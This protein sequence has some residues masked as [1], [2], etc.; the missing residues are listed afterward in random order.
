[1]SESGSIFGD[2]GWI[3]DIWG[4]LNN[5]DDKPKAGSEFSADNPSPTWGQDGS[6]TEEEAGP[7]EEGNSFWEKAASA[8]GVT[9]DYLKE[10]PWLQQ[11]VR[12]AGIRIFSD[13][14]SFD[15]DRFK[16]A[17][18]DTTVMRS[19]DYFNQFGQSQVVVDPETGKK[20][21]TGEMA[22]WLTDMV[23]A[24]VSRSASPMNAYQKPEA[25]NALLGEYIGDREDY[26]G[27]PRSGSKGSQHNVGGYGSPV[28]IDIGGPMSPKAPG[29]DPTGGGSAPTIEDNLG[30]GNPGAL[31]PP[32]LIEPD[33]G[34]TGVGQGED[35][36]TGVGQNQPGYIDR[37]NQGLI[38]GWSQ[39]QDQLQ[40]AGVPQGEIDSLRNYYERGTNGE[41]GFE[42][43][44]HWKN[45]VGSALAAASGN[46][47]RLIYNIGKGLFDHFRHDP[48]ETV[49]VDPNGETVRDEYLPPGQ[50]WV[51]PGS[52]SGLYTGDGP[53]WGIPYNPGMPA[54][55]WQV[56][57]NTPPQTSDS[58][59]TVGS[60]LIG[61]PG[62]G[63]GVGDTM[64]V[65]GVTYKYVDGKWIPQ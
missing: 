48:W 63:I 2:Y 21:V 18:I 37:E 55:F 14:P 23:N 6:V 27:I 28:N 32:G 34:D 20:T 54:D 30:Y 3:G 56:G 26:F 53:D 36:G 40:S 10:N 45:I 46:P 5:D 12:Q 52:D 25:F 8:F 42:F 60:D 35:I 51:R 38:D 62:T 64:V 22:P 16:Q 1:M 47:L 39:W 44:N 65:D 4:A 7:V 59:G 58:G 57:G 13:K 49:P 11:L 31:P 19:P 15:W 50:D 24:M 29:A 9:I 61:V 43:K 41:F 17:Q 33:A